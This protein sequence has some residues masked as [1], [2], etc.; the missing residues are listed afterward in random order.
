MGSILR[1][2]LFLN[3]ERLTNAVVSSV[4]VIVWHLLATTDDSLSR[5]TNIPPKTRSASRFCIAFLG[6]SL[7]LQF[8]VRASGESVSPEFIDLLNG[9]AYIK[10]IEVGLPGQVYSI[11]GKEG[12]GWS[13]YEAC[14]QGETF[15]I[16][17]AT[18]SIPGSGPPFPGYIEGA[19][20]TNYWIYYPYGTLPL[21]GLTSSAKGSKTIEA[22][23]KEVKLSLS[24]LRKASGLG[25]GVEPGSLNLGENNQFTARDENGG[26]IKGT[27]VVGSAGR[28]TS[29]QFTVSTFPGMKFT[30][31]YDYSEAASNSPVPSKLILVGGLD[32]RESGRLECRILNCEFGR[33]PLPD[34]GFTPDFVDKTFNAKAVVVSTLFSNS[35]AYSIENGKL[36]KIVSGNQGSNWIRRGLGRYAVISAIFSFPLLLWLISR[37]TGR[38]RVSQP[39]SG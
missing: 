16:K 28:P 14:V 10:H 39:K 5:C 37:A 20:S 19:S 31:S 12:V 18:N 1:R 25:I 35:A 29:C 24:L 3:L 26:V 11:N 38:Q 8:G 9:R 33:V 15:W 34:G 32:T 6:V 13:Y 2:A 27:F 21:H 22:P 23:E 4:G 30:T 7:V 36:V 17:S